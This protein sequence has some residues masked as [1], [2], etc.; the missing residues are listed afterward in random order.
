MAAWG[1]FRTKKTDLDWQWLY[2]LNWL[3]LMWGCAQGPAEELTPIFPGPNQ[4]YSERPTSSRDRVADIIC[5]LLQG[6]YPNEPSAE[7]L[8]TNPHFMLFVTYIYVTIDIE[9]TLWFGPSFFRIHFKKKSG[10]DFN[11]RYSSSTG[12]SPVWKMTL[13]WTFY[14][15]RE[16]DWFMTSGFTSIKNTHPAEAVQLR[17]GK[18]LEI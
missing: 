8:W 3:S 11:S 17:V 7:S 5:I 4:G 1:Y 12:E 10:Y 16:F 9:G 14:L 13:A 15:E 6:V 18:G 2:A